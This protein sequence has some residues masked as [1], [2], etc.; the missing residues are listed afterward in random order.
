MNNFLYRLVFNPVLFGLVLSLVVLHFMQPYVERRQAEQ[1]A[2]FVAT[3]P[4]EVIPGLNC[5]M[6]EAMPYCYACR[7]EIAD[8]SDVQITC[9]RAPGTP[10]P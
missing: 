8:P 3:F 6:I 9:S 7:R 4:I 10:Q 5:R 1:R 2:K